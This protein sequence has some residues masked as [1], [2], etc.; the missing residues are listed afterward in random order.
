MGV[1]D[2]TGV[3]VRND[4]FIVVLGKDEVAVEERGK[5]GDGQLVG[6]NDVTNVGE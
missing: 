5:Y 6:V 1:N 3:G 4:V 2:A